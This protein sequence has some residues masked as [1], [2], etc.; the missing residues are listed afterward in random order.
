VIPQC[1]KCHRELHRIG[2]KAFL[3]DIPKYIRIALKL[4]EVSGDE[5]AGKRIC[6]GLPF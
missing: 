4:Y 3:K 6:Q 1:A 5:K 2:E